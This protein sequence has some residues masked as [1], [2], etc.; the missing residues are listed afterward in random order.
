MHC[1]VYNQAIE[2]VGVIDS[3]KSLI[4][5]RSFY[6][7]GEFELVVP[8]TVIHQDLLQVQHYLTKDDRGEFGII[9]TIHIEQNEDGEWM[10]CSGRLGPSLL[11]RRI[12]YERVTI[13]NTVEMVMRTL[14]TTSCI[15]PNN[16]ARVMPNLMLAPFVGHAPTVT[17]QVTYRN[18]SQTLYELTRTHQIGWDIRLDPLQR[19]LVF[20][21][22]E[23]SDKT[24][25]Q[26]AGPQVIF[27]EDYENIRSSTYERNQRFKQSVVL[28][29]GQG[30][31]DERILVEVGSDEG[32]PRVEAFVNAKDLRWEAEMSESEYLD[33]LIQR[34]WQA[35]EPEVEYLEASVVLNGS[36]RLHDDFDLGDIVTIQQSRW[37]K[38]IEAQV[39][40]ISE[41]WDEQGITIQP[42][43]GQ[44]LSRVTTKSTP[45]TSGTSEGQSL[46]VTPNKAIVSDSGGNIIASSVSSQEVGYLSGVTSLVQTQ[47]NGK[48]ATISGAASSI[49]SSN[50][51][52]SRAL[53]SDGSGKVAVSSVTST[54]LGTLSGVTSAIQTQLDG[55]AANSHTHIVS[56]ITDFL[57]KVYPVG[58]IYMSTSATSPATLFGGTWAAIQNRFLVAAGATYSAG[59]TGGRASHAHTSAP[60]KHGAGFESGGD[61]DL[62]ATVTGSTGYVYFREDGT[63]PAS[64][65]TWPATHRVSGTYGTT[66]NSVGGGA[67]V[68]G[69]TSTTTPDSTGSSSSLPPYLSVYMWQRTA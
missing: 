56:Q 25:T 19:K 53:V 61:G 11:S 37:N 18:L 52:S 20:F 65:A 57:D 21:T 43:F 4:W 36:V 24:A 42:I 14:V 69:Y 10:T 41:V 22:Y 63:V 46:N 34:G 39:S 49:T 54:Q 27:S 58:A 23:P 13:S 62:W 6:E 28:V 35:I 47:L 55:K 5:H 38:T 7:S 50:L 51:T 45:D 30:E 17:M 8:V 40:E 64:Q 26:T 60:H 29:G 48:Q 33:A 59:S 68:R 67:D 3:I 2:W 44:S 31:G 12:I 15:T 66:S 16:P 1:K 9:E 32:S